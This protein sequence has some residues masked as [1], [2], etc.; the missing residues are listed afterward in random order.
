MITYIEQIPE[1][2]Y[3]II[4]VDEAQDMNPLY[5]KLVT[6]IMK[7]NSKDFKICIIGD[8]RQCI[9]QFNGSDHHFLTEAHVIFKEYNNHPWKECVMNTSYRI[10]R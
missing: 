9:N 4:I 8:K 10:T 3:D 6:Q 1:Q 5:F 7:K 2:K